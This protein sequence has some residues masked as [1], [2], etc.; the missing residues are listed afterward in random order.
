MLE[1]PTTV[2]LDRGAIDDLVLYPTSSAGA[3]N[4]YWLYHAREKVAAQF[5]FNVPAISS[6]V[7]PVARG[8]DRSGR[9]RRRTCANSCFTLSTRL[10]PLL[11]RHCVQLMIAEAK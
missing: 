5:S 4:R 3:A 10:R 1:Y 6:I 9:Y 7:Y 11:S 8:S 2:G